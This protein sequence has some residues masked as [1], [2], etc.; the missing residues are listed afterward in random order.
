M[1]CPICKQHSL[2]SVTLTC[3]LPGNRC[4]NCAGFWISSLDYFSWLRAHKQFLP[5]RPLQEAALPSSQEPH[6][7]KICPDCGHLLTRYKIWPNINFF[8]D[9]C[10]SC[11]GVWLDK[12]EWDVL[13]KHNLQDNLNEFFTKPWQ[14][15]LRASETKTLL[16]KLYT[17]KFGAEDYVQA[18]KIRA[19]LR[20]HPAS[21]MILA[22]L[23]AEDPYKI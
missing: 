23:E 1:K 17:Q 9:H 13:G 14:R 18:K 6:T 15:N 7:A 4:S 8:L 21:A 11:N 2:V 5:D 20:E 12:G 10:G 22:Y 3:D 19:W 16:E